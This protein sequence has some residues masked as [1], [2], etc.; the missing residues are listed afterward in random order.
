MGFNKLT[1]FEKP[2]TL[3]DRYGNQTKGAGYW[4]ARRYTPK[5]HHHA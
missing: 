2:G 3:K 4:Q 1:I 5:N